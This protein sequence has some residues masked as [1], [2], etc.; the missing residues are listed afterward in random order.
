MQS[1][2]PALLPL[3]RSAVV[4]ELLAWLFLHPE[5]EFTGAEL[6]KKIR[7]SPAS[8]SREADRLVS[9]GLVRE[10]RLGNLRLLRAETGSIVARP[11]Q[12][13]LSVTYGPLPILAVE[14]GKLTNV[15]EAYIYGSWAARYLGE[16]GPIPHD[17]DVL[18]VGDADE[19]ELYDAARAAESVLAREVNIRRVSAEAWAADPGGDPF[20]QTVRA[21]PL[22]ALIVGAP[23]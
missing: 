2:P 16:P 4:G 9:A 1:P 6:A 3:L 12:D 5:K 15:T 19:D 11:L 14:L 13:L 23:A 21:R 17:V 22:V 10:R 20:L 8:T 18:V 7:T